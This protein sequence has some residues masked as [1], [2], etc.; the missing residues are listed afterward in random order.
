MYLCLTLYRKT[1]HNYSYGSIIIHI[2]LH[3]T[4]SR[5][6]T[7]LVHMENWSIAKQFGPGKPAQPDLNKKILEDALSL[8]QTTN[9]STGPN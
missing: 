2:V 6:R 9:F 3:T 5:G 1:C 4:E 8:Y 7:V